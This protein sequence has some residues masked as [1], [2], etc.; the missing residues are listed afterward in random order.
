MFNDLKVV[1]ANLYAP[2]EDDPGYF[3]K[4]FDIVLGIEADDYIIGGDFNKTLNPQLDRK[5]IAKSKLHI[6]TSAE[7]INKFLNDNDW[8]DVWRHGHPEEKYFTWHRSK[9][10]TFSRLD[11]FLI[12]QFQLAKVQ[13]CEIISNVLSDHDSVLL[14]LDF[15][16]I[17]RGPGYWKFNNSLLYK[18]DFVVEVNQHI[19]HLLAQPNNLDPSDRWE[20]LK[21]SL[22]EFVQWK[23]RKKAHENK[24]RKD[25]LDKKERVLKKK[26]HCI[27][28]NSEHI[29]AQI[30][31]INDKLD[32]IQIQLAEIS[33]ERAQG[34]M[35]RS[36]A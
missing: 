6:T 36:K 16:N 10:I 14:H 1:I 28:L 9:P 15:D 32:K 25:M 7:L 19:D 34:A 22:I 26:L 2:N 27:N 20:A 3:Q 13:Q 35:L 21:L 31:A 29:I 4:V 18:A 33:K 5:T 17:K 8:V 24:I 23:A 30:E 12:P 11:Y